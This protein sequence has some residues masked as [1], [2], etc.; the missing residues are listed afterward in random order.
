M[1]EENKSMTPQEIKAWMEKRR[2]SLYEG[3]G[4]DVKKMQ[5]MA[6]QF[7]KKKKEDISK[8]AQEKYKEDVDSYLNYTN[9][10][11]SRS[12]VNKQRQTKIPN[13]FERVP[14][15]DKYTN[16]LA[17]LREQSSDLMKHTVGETTPIGSNS[18]LRGYVMDVKFI[19]PNE[20]AVHENVAPFVSSIIKRLPNQKTTVR[21]MAIKAYVPGCY[22]D[23]PPD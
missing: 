12:R 1:S 22:F 16:V 8:K 11:L 7:M 15:Q 21:L 10:L 3:A 6:S 13:S 23:I 5:E 14:G 19:P 18:D 4:V 2:A 17:S 9:M 20:W